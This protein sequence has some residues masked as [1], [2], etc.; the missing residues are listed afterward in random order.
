MFK[1]GS[2]PWSGLAKTGAAL[3]A[4]AF[5]VSTCSGLR[6]FEA[7]ISEMEGISLG[8]SRD[9]VLY[10][11]GVPPRV[12][13]DPSSIEMDGKTIN[14]RTLYWTSG[15]PAPVNAMPMG[16][17]ISD[18]S[19]WSYS[20]SRGEAAFEVE[21]D[22]SGRVIAL[23]CTAKGGTPYACG[24]VAGIRNTDTE[25]TVRRMGR[26][27]REELDGVTKLMAYDDIGVQFLLTK[28]RVYRIT[29]AAPGA[30]PNA[31]VGRFLERRFP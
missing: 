25:E 15:A 4:V 21:F 11:L 2:V 24:P 5:T 12:L 20:R 23:E 16:K 17:R 6:E 8:D 18:F 27:T 3:I 29:L 22:R 31:A 19:G 28:G 14:V 7:E 9:E 10:R 1:L 30:Q 13:A 26:P